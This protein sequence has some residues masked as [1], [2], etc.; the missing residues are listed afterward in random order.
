MFWVDGLVLVQDNYSYVDNIFEDRIFVI[1][2]FNIKFCSY[3]TI[4]ISVINFRFVVLE[5]DELKEKFYSF[6]YFILM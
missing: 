1:L 6:Y 2:L 4:F 3:I 5:C